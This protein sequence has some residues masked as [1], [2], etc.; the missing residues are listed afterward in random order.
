MAVTAP[1]AALGPTHPLYDLW[2]PIWALLE[3]CAD[4]TGGFL[5][6]T[7]LI[8]HPREWLDHDKP[9]PTQPTKKLLERRRLARY[10]NLANLILTLKLEG[11]F[12][13]P[14]VRRVVRPN[15]EAW[16]THP[17]LDWVS[18]DVDGD[19]RPLEAVLSAAYRGALTFGHMFL[20]LD[21]ARD[22][23]PTAAD[24][25]PLVLRTYRPLDAP[26]WLEVRGTLSAIKLVEALPRTSL[27]QPA[28]EAGWRIYQITDTR[29]TVTTVEGEDQTVETIDHRFGVLP[30]V[31]LYAHRRSLTS[32]LG[33]SA[34]ADPR[35]YVDLFNLTSEVRELLRK[36]TFSILNIPLGKGVDG[37]TAITV[38]QAQAMIGQTNGTANV[39]F[40]AEAANY[41]S[42]D[43]ANVTVYQE[44]RQ[45]LIRTIFRL[46]K[47]PFQ[48]DSREAE[49]AEAQREKR[50]DFSTTLAGYADRLREAELALAERWYRGHFGAGWERHWAAGTPSV[51]YPQT[52]DEPAFREVL[53]QAE[54]ALAL[55]LGESKTFR[56][57]HATKLISQFLPDASHE[58]LQAIRAELEAQPT[59]E[60]ARTARLGELGA[61]F[62]AS[63]RDE[64]D[65]ETPPADDV[66]PSLPPD[67]A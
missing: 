12:R 67:E 19:G 38:E 58:V 44:E 63:V 37:G 26:D 20:V 57:E 33:E 5:D 21:R 61:R 41:I 64:A 29:T 43:T 40:T 53:E 9:N 55:P 49:T 51:S 8:A 48:Q 25:A 34:L 60:E 50:K 65:E 22:D 30:V 62:R 16:E 46:C 24:R 14:A 56:V 23:G 3:D 13:E 18:G 32:V 59:P 11:L 54:A 36:Q 27:D 52:F 6:G 66:P 28:S 47:V 10:E 1:R 7:Y 15:G 35:L 31:P 17:Y 39:L 4:G 42:A 2:A 45:Q